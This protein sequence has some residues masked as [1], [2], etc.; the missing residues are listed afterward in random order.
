MCHLWL[1]FTLL[2]HRTVSELL[3]MIM[4]MHM[5]DMMQVVKVLGI[6]PQTVVIDAPD[7][8][9][10][11]IR[12]H[13][14]RTHRALARIETHLNDYCYCYCDVLVGP[15]GPIRYCPS[16]F[17]LSCIRCNC[18]PHVQQ[19]PERLLNFTFHIFPKFHIREANLIQAFS[20]LHEPSLA[21]SCSHTY[22]CNAR[23]PSPFVSEDSHFSMHMHSTLL[24][25]LYHV[26]RWSVSRRY[27]DLDVC[28]SLDWIVIVQAALLPPVCPLFVYGRVYHAESYHHAGSEDDDAWPYAS[29]TL[30]SYPYVMGPIWVDGCVCSCHSYINKHTSQTSTSPGS[31]APGPLGILGS[32][33]ITLRCSAHGY[34]KI[35]THF[36]RAL[37]P[38]VTAP[39]TRSAWPRGVPCALGVL[40]DLPPAY[41][42][43]SLLRSAMSLRCIDYGITATVKLGYSFTFARMVPVP[44]THNTSAFGSV[45][46]SFS[47]FHHILN[48]HLFQPFVHLWSLSCTCYTGRDQCV[49][50]I[51]LSHCRGQHEREATASHFIHLFSHTLGSCDLFHC[52]D[53]LHTFIPCTFAHRILSHLLPTADLVASL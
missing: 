49:A 16:H 14:I 41:P 45:L 19:Y 21:R 34:M 11:R 29:R 25:H 50:R 18:C 3:I 43:V 1:I 17:A 15:S 23:Y 4:V 10:G 22:P 8:I 42:S 28:D 24:A 53:I 38:P 39:I 31:L 32:L 47:L 13:A 40:M 6:H 27:Y 9:R 46:R 7:S 52:L 33:H 36:G 5:Q 20:L 30:L 26:H 37:S 2:T 51:F 12:V 48:F 35:L 44:S